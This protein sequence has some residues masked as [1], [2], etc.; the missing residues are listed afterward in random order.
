MLFNPRVFLHRLV[1]YRGSP[2]DDPHEL[3]V[4]QIAE[5][6]SCKGDDVKTE[7]WRIDFHEVLHAGETYFF[8]S[9]APNVQIGGKQANDEDTPKFGHDCLFR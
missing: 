6:S 7:E 1:C 2:K 4:L 3:G 9:L 8:I 5:L